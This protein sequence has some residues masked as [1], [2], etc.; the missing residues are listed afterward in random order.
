M[1]LAAAS[2][3]VGIVRTAMSGEPAVD[4]TLDGADMRL[5]LRLTR[6]KV[7]GGWTRG[8]YEVERDG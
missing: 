4:G 7:A 1:S 8:G 6:D 5:R 2:V 3:S